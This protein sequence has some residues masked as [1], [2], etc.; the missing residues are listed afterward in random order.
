MGFKVIFH[1]SVYSILIY[2]SRLSLRSPSIASSKGSKTS[3]EVSDILSNSLKLMA[4]PE[5]SARAELAFNQSANKCED[6]EN[7]VLARIL[8]N[9]TS[10]Q[11]I[12][13]SPVRCDFSRKSSLKLKEKIKD[14]EEIN[15]AF[16]NRVM[17][18]HTD[19]KSCEYDKIRVDGKV[20]VDDKIQV[21]D[22]VLHRLLNQ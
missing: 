13:K 12:I 19:D 9:A 17:N 8:G 3:K 2:S 10:S 4:N 5:C 6:T 1:P 21:D 11:A 14:Y 22:A 20:H 15:E 7:F 16:I 18:N